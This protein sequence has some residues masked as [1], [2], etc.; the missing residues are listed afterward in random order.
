MFQT[1]IVAKLSCGKW[2]ERTGTQFYLW[3]N[4]QTTCEI[5]H[6]NQQL[7]QQSSDNGLI[8]AWFNKPDVPIVGRSRGAKVH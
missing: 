5:A 4:R 2:L 1:V 8:L 6:Q 7:E 3:I